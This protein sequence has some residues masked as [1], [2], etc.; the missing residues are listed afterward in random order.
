M[1]TGPFNGLHGLRYIHPECIYIY[2]LYFYLFIYVCMYLFI[3]IHSICISSLLSL[4]WFDEVFHGPTY[5]VCL[6]IEDPEIDKIL[7]GPM[8]TS[9][10]VY[11]LVI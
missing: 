5:W 8:N 4:M 9:L 6:K 1:F 3:Y 11:P 2:I 10:R 7:I